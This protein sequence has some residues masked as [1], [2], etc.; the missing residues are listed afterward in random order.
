MPEGVLIFGVW[1]KT[2]RCD[3]IHADLG[4]TQEDLVWQGPIQALGIS[5]WAVRR[6]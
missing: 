1:T 3:S 2:M 5:R 4:D 6:D